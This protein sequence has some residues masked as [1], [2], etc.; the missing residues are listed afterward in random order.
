MTSS[1]EILSV[2]ILSTQIDN[3]LVYLDVIA[4]TTF[5]SS[6]SPS[7]TTFSHSKAMRPMSH[8]S[9]MSTLQGT[10]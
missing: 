5:Q 10:R 9:T 6:P 8:M 1:V 7:Y 2:E 4:L 3:R